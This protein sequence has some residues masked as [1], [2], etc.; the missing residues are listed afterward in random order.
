MISQMND[1]G[2]L[3]VRRGNGVL[4]PKQIKDPMQYKSAIKGY[5]ETDYIEQWRDYLRK[6]IV[7]RYAIP[8]RMRSRNYSPHPE[9]IH[10]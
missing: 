10:R 7:V 5:Y 6:A 1:S 8:G 9:S 2:Q 4:G 3:P